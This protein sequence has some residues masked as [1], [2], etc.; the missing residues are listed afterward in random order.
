LTGIKSGAV[1]LDKASAICR[2]AGR[3]NE[4][5]FA[6]TRVQQILQQMN[7]EGAALGKTPIGESE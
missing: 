5:F 1:D 2:V 6:E 4:S 3:I 7:K